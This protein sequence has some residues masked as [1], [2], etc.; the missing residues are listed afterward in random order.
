MPV[1][2][3]VNVAHESRVGCSQC[4]NNNQART[5]NKD[6]ERNKACYDMLDQRL[7]NERQGENSLRSD[8]SRTRW[9]CTAIARHINVHSKTV[10]TP[11]Q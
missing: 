2:E 8:A 1:Y 6:S 4:H 9:K 10:A 3:Y 7:W 5:A 11:H